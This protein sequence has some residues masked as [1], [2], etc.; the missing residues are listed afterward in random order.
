MLH[1]LCKSLGIPSDPPRK[2][3]A[4]GKE[5]GEHQFD[6]AERLVRATRICESFEEVPRFGIARAQGVEFAWDTEAAEEKLVQLGGVKVP[7]VA[8]KTEDD[9]RVEEE[10]LGIKGVTETFGL[11]SR[12]G[13]AAALSSG[14][15]VDLS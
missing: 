6:R 10:E 7:M 14:T 1:S 5:D 9:G 4:I 13:F 15:Y 2:S 12:S 8:W 3:F 11:R